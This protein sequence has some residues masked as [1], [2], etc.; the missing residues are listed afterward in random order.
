MIMGIGCSCGI[1]EKKKNLF[2]A[3]GFDHLFCF[4]GG[5]AVNN[6]MSHGFAGADAHVDAHAVAV[7][8][9]LPLR[10][11]FSLEGD[12][13]ADPA[14]YLRRPSYSR[15]TQG[16]KPPMRTTENGSTQ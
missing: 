15:T 2:R 5:F 12:L 8:M 11:R 6:E 4:E 1:R 3:E 7:Q 13:A 16:S 10:Y 9:Y 14:T